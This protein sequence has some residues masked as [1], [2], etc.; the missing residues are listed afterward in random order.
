MPAAGCGERDQP[1]DHGAGDE[2]GRVDDSQTFTIAVTNVNDN[3]VSAV[4]DTDAGAD[5][6]AENA[7]NGT[8]VGVTARR[9]TLT[10]VRR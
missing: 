10:W 4:A 3:P 9:R 7:A 5:T 2:L 8:A 6:V 1:P